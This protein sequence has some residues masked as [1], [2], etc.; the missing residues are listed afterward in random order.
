MRIRKNGIFTLCH[1][2]EGR[3]TENDLN[4]GF[5]PLLTGAIKVKKVSHIS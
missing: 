4:F 5:G 2:F 3:Q 1:K